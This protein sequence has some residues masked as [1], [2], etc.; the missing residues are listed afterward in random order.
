MNTDPKA[1][2]KEAYDLLAQEKFKAAFKAF[3]EAGYLYRKQRNHKQSAL[4]FAS[5]ASCWSKKAGEKVF[6]NSALSYEEAA[7]E[8][9]K[10]MDFEYASLL[11]KYAAINYERDMEF[12]NFSDCFYRSKEIFRKF[13]TYVLFKPKKIRHIEKSR[14]VRG[15]R[16][17]IR[18]VFLWLLLTLSWA[19]WGY[20]E[21]P[22]RTFF[23]GISVVCLFALLYTFL[24]LSKGGI[25]YRPDF[26][27]A[28]YFSITTF[29][30]V[31]YGD[32]TPVGLSKAVVMVESFCGIFV[33]PLFVIGLSRKYL[34]V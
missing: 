18:H 31:G 14:Q 4:C 16:G 13:L 17:F 27:E 29:T 6:Y 24:G 30:T 20:G 1:L 3:N 10:A 26:L 15:V 33:I 7:K 2:E 21:R 22:S 5:A 34:R 9:E 19:V 25:V 28:L 11:Y 8:A 23:S 32:I 12:F